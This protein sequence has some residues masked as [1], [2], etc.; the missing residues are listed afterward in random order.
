[1][2][3]LSLSPVFGWFGAI[4]AALTAGVLGWLAHGK[5]VAEAHDPDREYR[6]LAFRLRHPWKARASWFLGV[7]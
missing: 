1:M 2:L 7:D 3:T 4:M 5:P 6:K